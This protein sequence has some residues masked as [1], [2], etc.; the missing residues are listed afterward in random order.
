MRPAV[1]YVDRTPLRGRPRITTRLSLVSEVESRRNL[2]QNF[3]SE[4]SRHFSSL[5]APFLNDANRKK[6]FHYQNFRVK[7]A[8]GS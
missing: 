7:S 5:L 3:S 6:F 1:N 4:R 2:A 8:P